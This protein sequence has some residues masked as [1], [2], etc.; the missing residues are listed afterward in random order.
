VTS[1]DKNHTSQLIFFKISLNRDEFLVID[2]DRRR[3]ELE[4]IIEDSPLL[5]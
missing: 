2:G 5:K 1:A 3:E 4:E